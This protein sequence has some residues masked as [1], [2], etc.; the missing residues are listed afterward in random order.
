MA[1]PL[2]GIT[3]DIIEHNGRD[4]AAAPVTYGLAVERAGGV[5]LL[6]QPGATDPERV[7]H[8]LDGLVLI[9]GDDPIMEPFGVATHPE[10]EP[11]R[12]E[13]QEGEMSLLRTVESLRPELPVLGVCLGMQM[14]AL[15]HGGTLD[16]HLPESIDRAEEHWENKHTVIPLGDDSPIPPGAVF[17][18]H[19]Q[20]LAD[21]GSLAI[22]ARSPDGLVEAVHDPARPFYVGVQWHPELSGDDPLGQG[23][24]DR[25]VA[26]AQASASESST[27]SAL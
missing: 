18:R 17:S 14:M 20:A 19:R 1:K 5:P 22:S 21:P 24:Y 23:L 6:L 7:V 10:A 25:L 13:R 9:G 15:L 8:L 3:T 2:I 12:R 27:P 4:R 16:Q 11:V 26:A